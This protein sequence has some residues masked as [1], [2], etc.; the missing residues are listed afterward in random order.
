VPT[1]AAELKA[2]VATIIWW[3]LLK[4]LSLDMFYRGGLDG[5][6]MRKWFPSCRR[7]LHLKTCFQSF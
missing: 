6:K 2:F 7:F 1:T 4:S 3:C 5:L